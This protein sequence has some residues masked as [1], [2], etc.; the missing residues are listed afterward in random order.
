M[1]KPRGKTSQQNPLPERERVVSWD[2]YNFSVYVFA[3]MKFKR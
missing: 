2:V 1:V 3:S